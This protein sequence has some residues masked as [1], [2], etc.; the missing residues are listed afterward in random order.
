MTSPAASAPPPALPALSVPERRRTSSYPPAILQ[1]L[2]GRLDGRCKR[3]LGDHFG[4]RNFG[5][6]LTTLAP[7]ATSAL[8]HAH[9][10]QDEFVFVLAGH[11]TLHCA[12]ATQQLFPGMC[13]G[14]AAGD[15]R[16]HCLVNDTDHDVTL[17]EIGDRTAGDVVSYP[18]VDLS[19]TFVQ[20]SWVFSRRDGT[21]Y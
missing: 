16:A 10:K 3:A 12:S 20:G 19:A 2:A 4:L 1:V 11:P 7:G 6:N 17:L 8:R 9:Q 18:D 5:V 14:F 21:P 15:G 13:V